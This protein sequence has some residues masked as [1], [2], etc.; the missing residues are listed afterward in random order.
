MYGL[1][2]FS[3]GDIAAIVS[4]VAAVGVLLGGLFGWGLNHLLRNESRVAKLEQAAKDSGTQNVLDMSR[5]EN[6][7]DSLDK[8][9]DSYFRDD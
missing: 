7:L 3:T 9:I 2:A 4:A 5:I 8:K 1:Y 6:K